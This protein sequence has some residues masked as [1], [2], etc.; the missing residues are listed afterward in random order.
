MEQDAFW[1]LIG[2]MGA[3]PDDE[4]IERLADELATR[5]ASEIVA[6]A[7]QLA[8]AL[9]AL[10]T[11]AHARA[12]RARGDW[13]LYV[14][15]AAVCA[16]RATYE[17]ILAEPKKLRRFALRDAEPL[18]SVAPNAYERSAGA[19]WHHESPVSY[20]S[21]SNIAGWGG[22]HEADRLPLWLRLLAFVLRPFFRNRPDPDEG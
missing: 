3:E 15:C 5:P 13:F 1:R 4:A 10:D 14:R 12:A 11:R 6:F 9:H 2:T 18:L 22:P 21:G 19:G 7:D 17:Q 8:F 16:G 20:E